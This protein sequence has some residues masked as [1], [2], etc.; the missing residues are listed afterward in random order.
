MSFVV[1]NKVVKTPKK[2]PKKA[3]VV[4]TGEASLCLLDIKFSI[5]RDTVVIGYDKAFPLFTEL[6]GIKLDYWTWT[7]PT[8]VFEG[9]SKYYEMDAELRPKIIVPH[10]MKDLD[11]YSH[12]WGFHPMT[13]SHKEVKKLYKSSTS[14]LERDGKLIS[15]EKAISTKNLPK[16]SVIFSDPST[17][18]SDKNYYFDNELNESVLT[19]SIFPICQYLKVKEVYCIGFDN[20]GTSSNIPIEL[21]DTIKNKIR[22][23][24]H[25]WQ[26]LHKMNIYDLYPPGFLPNHPF[27]KTIPVGSILKK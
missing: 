3:V 8:T 19:S 14:K 18:F 4:G 16:E 10:W 9:L 7:D 1:K 24:A 20:Q 27:L 11:E 23:W 5:P 6:T 2:N 15:I 21:G 26:P 17:R 13:R 12:H 25:K 22:L